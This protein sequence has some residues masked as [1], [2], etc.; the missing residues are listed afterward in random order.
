MVDRAI[1]IATLKM[2]IYGVE[3]VITKPVRTI[4]KISLKEATETPSSSGEV[5]VTN[6]RIIDETENP[7]SMK[8]MSGGV[9][10]GQEN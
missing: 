7:S 9:E 5:K 4:D 10:G 8:D 6:V 2:G 3:V 1:A